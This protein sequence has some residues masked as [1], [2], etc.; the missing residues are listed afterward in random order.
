[1]T[2]HAG[3]RLTDRLGLALPLIQAGMGGI[4]GPELC[5][6]VSLAGA[7]GVLALYKEPPERVAALI[8]GTAAITGRPFGVNLIPEVAGPGLVLA[9]TRTAVEA[10]PPGGFVTVFGLPDEN[11]AGLVRAARRP[12][13]VQVGTERDADLAAALGADVIVLQGQDAGG[14]LL[15]T[16]PARELLSRVR[17]RHPRATLLTAGGT[18]TGA[19]LAAA[20]RAGADGALAGT[21]FAT[22]TES[23]AHDGFKRRVVNAGADDTVVTGIY[24][25]GWPRRRHRVLRNALTGAARRPARFIATTTM[26]GRDW[27]VS[28]YSAAAPL[29]STRGLVEEMAMYCGRSCERVTGIRT[30][31][32]IV[33]D[34][35]SSGGR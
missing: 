25:I 31:A 22:A 5:A 11:T 19:D 2:G 13:L 24:D 10:L 9:Q 1:V 28:R 4:A 20:L 7:G 30:A 26:G 32:E 14:H 33:G 12:L 8:A 21:V 17:A 15:G 29:R 16:L 27:P 3:E 34:F 6:A 18:A 23:L 35:A